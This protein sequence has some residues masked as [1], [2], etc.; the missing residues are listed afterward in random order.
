MSEIKK[1]MI[2]WGTF[3]FE[4]W[5]LDDH[6]NAEFKRLMEVTSSWSTSL[7]ATY[8]APYQLWR[9]VHAPEAEPVTVKFNLLESYD[10]RDRLGVQKLYY[11]LQRHWD[12]DD[13]SSIQQFDSVR[14]EGG[15]Y[16]LKFKKEYYDKIVKPFAESPVLQ[17]LSFRNS[18]EGVL[19]DVVPVN[20]PESPALGILGKRISPFD[21]LIETFNGVQL[22]WGGGNGR[23]N[24]VWDENKNLIFSL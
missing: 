19:A 11:S 2:Q 7:T 20:A 5:N 13:K 21:T 8:D 1:N 22:I 12:Y 23:L 6:E 10:F 16:I 15:A 9:D 18:V 4:N 3:N 24:Q 14:L 17:G